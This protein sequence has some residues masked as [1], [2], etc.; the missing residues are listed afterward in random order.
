MKRNQN[1]QE[2]WKEKYA[3]IIRWLLNNMDQS[4]N[5]IVVYL[6]AAKEIWNHLADIYSNKKNIPPTC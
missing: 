2:I 5:N 6:Q 4:V 1:I 3:T